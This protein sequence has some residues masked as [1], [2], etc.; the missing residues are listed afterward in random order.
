MVPKY[1]YHYTDIDTVKKII[2]SKKI[3]FKR[4][5]LLNDPYE[6]VHTLDGLAAYGG[7]MRKLIYCSCWTNILQE[8]VNLW[9]IYSNMQGARIKM[10]ST[11]FSNEL[12]LI[13]QASGFMP[14]GKIDA[15]KDV[16]WVGDKET[17]IDKIYGPFKVEYVEQL[18]DT[19][20]LAVGVSKCKSGTS[21]E[22]LM[23]DIDLRELGNRKI[24]H[25]E[26]ENEWRYKICPYVGVHGG[27]EAFRV[28]DFSYINSPDYID[29]PF[30][31][32]IEEIMVGPCVSEQEVEDLVKFLEEKENH[33]CVQRSSIRIC[34]K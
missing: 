19:Y 16:P 1:L 27:T 30:T 13:E 2:E 26:Y 21:D 34:K 25:W 7:E 32:E 3:R 5:D 28:N 17:V 4:L 24:K 22:F 8:T 11:M 10:K 18:N 9:A 12:K 29:I 6:G 20:N 23:H 33:I 15:I 31:T 14:V